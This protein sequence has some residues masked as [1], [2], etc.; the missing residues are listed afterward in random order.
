MSTT[1]TVI[2]STVRLELANTDSKMTGSVG[3]QSGCAPYVPGGFRGR[4][5]SGHRGSHFVRMREMARRTVMNESAKWRSGRAFERTVSTT[6][7]LPG[8]GSVG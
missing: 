7:R 4:W 5:H 3:D 6:P 8:G 2:P 1:N